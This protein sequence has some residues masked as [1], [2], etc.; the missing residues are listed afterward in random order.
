MLYLFKVSVDGVDDEGS[1]VSRSEFGFESDSNTEFNPFSSAGSAGKVV[2][3]PTSLNIFQQPN[4][5]IKVCYS[6][7]SYRFNRIFQEGEKFSVQP[8]IELLDETGARVR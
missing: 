5:Q 8:W 4:S 7:W 2:T 6:N 1:P 3:A